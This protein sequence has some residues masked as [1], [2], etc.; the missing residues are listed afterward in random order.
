[1]ANGFKVDN[2]TGAPGVQPWSRGEVY[3]LVI[4]RVERYK[5]FAEINRNGPRAD[6]PTKD[7]MIRRWGFDEAE[8]RFYDQFAATRLLYTQWDVLNADDGM[9]GFASY[10]DA[11]TAAKGWLAAQ[12]ARAVRDYVEA[13]FQAWLI[14]S[15]EEC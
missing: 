11:L 8:R 5:T 1:M 2:A 12:A 6:D 3:P 7:Y 14:L 9:S 4:A 15:S 10:D 13:E